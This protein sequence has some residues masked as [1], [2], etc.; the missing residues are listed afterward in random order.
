M[1]VLTEKKCNFHQMVSRKIQ[2]ARLP[3]W[4]A[5]RASPPGSIS[6][7]RGQ[8]LRDGGDQRWL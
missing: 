7:T 3:L 1:A 2:P 6:P 5:P 4:A 8:T